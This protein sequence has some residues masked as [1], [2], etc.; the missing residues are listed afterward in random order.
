MSSPNSQAARA[1]RGPPRSGT[2]RS[3]RYQVQPISF[4]SATSTDMAGARCPSG[5]VNM[6]RLLPFASPNAHVD[7]PP[8]GHAS[9]SISLLSHTTK[10]SG[11][12]RGPSN[13]GGSAGATSGQL[14]WKCR[15]RVGNF[16]PPKRQTC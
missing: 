1:N 4:T 12:F 9:E 8:P 2:R 3:P 14:G 6:S 15:R 7:L 13:S 16:F 10:S 5:L 11:R